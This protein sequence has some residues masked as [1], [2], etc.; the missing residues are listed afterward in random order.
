MSDRSGRA[1]EGKV[2]VVDD[3]EATRRLVVKWIEQT[4]IKC[5]EAQNGMVALELVEAHF[6]EID[7]MVLD[8][9][10]PGINGFEVL[11]RMHDDP[12]LKAMPV[13]LLTAHAEED[14]DIVQGANLGAL[15]HL[16]KPFS[17]PVLRAKVQR[18]VERR[19]SE[20]QLESKLRQA[21]QLARI[22][23]LTQLGNRQLFLERLREETAYAMRHRTPVC[24]VL[25][26]LDHFKSVNDTYGHDAGDEVLRHFAKRLSAAVRQEDSAFRYGGEEFV[27]LL[28]NSDKSGGRVA[29]ERLRTTL[30]LVPARLIGTKGEGAKGEPA[31]EV[32]YFVGFSAG[33]AV[34]DEGN[35]FLT[36]RLLSRADEA[37]YRAKEGGRNRDEIAD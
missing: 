26:D 19:R 36:E 8:V 7:L 24:L 10:M 23:T 27:L 5:L 12:V 16:G 22:D 29:T 32:E 18:A 33:I 28:R 31:A 3:D 15:D 30:R 37:L 13:I 20:K 1:N 4:G 35:E 9:M 21:E 2:L 17:G 34:A 14:S 11:R 25:M 6:S